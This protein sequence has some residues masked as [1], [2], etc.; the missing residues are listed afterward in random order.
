MKQEQVN[1]VSQMQE[2]IKLLMQPNTEIQVH[3]LKMTFYYYYFN[4]M[5]KVEI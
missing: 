2:E 5:F 4:S 1:K 3:Q